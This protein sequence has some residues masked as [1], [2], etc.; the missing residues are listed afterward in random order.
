MAKSKWEVTCNYVAGDRLY[1]VYRLRDENAIDHSGNREFATGYMADKAKA[2]RIAD[3]MNHCE[4]CK[5]VDSVGC[6]GCQY[7]PATERNLN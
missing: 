5:K 4:Q 3:R 2:Q 6:Y 7:D 1:A